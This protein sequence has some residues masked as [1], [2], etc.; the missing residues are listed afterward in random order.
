MRLNRLRIMLSI[1][2]LLLIVKSSK[3]QTGFS[4]N[5]SRDTLVPGCPTNL[6]ITLK[7]IIPDIHGQTSDYSLNPGSFNSA[8]FPVY[9]APNDPSGTPTNLTVDDT[10]SGIINLSFNFPFF[11]TVY[12]SLVASTN[13]Y[14]S[15]DATLAGGS[16]HWQ[17][18]GNLPNPLYDRALIMGPYHDLDPGVNTSPTMRIQ[19]QEFGAAPYRKWILSFYKVPLFSGACNNLIENT[20]Q[21]ILFESTGIIEVKIFD[22]QICSGWNGGKAMVGIQ[23]FTRTLGMTA[24]NRRMSDPPWGSIGMNETWR[25]VPNAGPSLLK[26]V[27][28][29]NMAGVLI[30]T[31]TT[32]PLLPGC[33]EASFPNI[34]APAGAAT[35]YE[36]R[37]I[38]EKIDDPAIEIVGRDTVV[39]NRAQ[40]LTGTAT[41]T[42]ANCGTNNGT[43]TVSGVTGG[44]PPY[45]YSLDGTNWQTSNVF[46]GLAPGSYTV[47]IRDVGS[48]CNITLPPV[49][50]A[51]VGN[52][53]A[54][55]TT[56]PT[57][58]F[59]S[60]TGSITITTAGGTGPYTFSLD[61]AA[62]V[63][64][65]L[66]FTFNNVAAGLHT[67]QVNDLGTGCTSGP[68]SVNVATGAGVSGTATATATACPGVNSGTIT[69]TALTGT[70]P[71]TWSL[72]GGPFL[73]GASPYTFTNVFG[74]THNVTIRDNF[75]CTV[76]IPNINVPFGPGVSGNAVTTATSCT[77]TNDGTITVTALT[78]TAP[79]TWSIDG[80]PF[81]PGASPYTFTNVSP[82]LHNITIV[83]NLN[84]S[85]LI[86]VTVA[87]GP[88]P[89]ATVNSTAT[90]CTGVN[91][92]TITVT[93]ASMPG[94]YTFSL[95]GGAPVAGT[96]PFTFNNVS[97]G[98]HNVVVTGAAGCATSQIPVTVTTGTGVTGSASTSSTSCPT[99]SNGSITVTATAGTAPF[100]WSLDGGAAVAGNSPYT[101]NNVAAGNHTVLIT[102]ALGCT[103]LIDPIVVAA[104]PALTANGVGMATTCSGASNGSIIVTALSGMAPYTFSLNGGPPQSGPSPFTFNNLAAGTYTVVVT[105]A[106]GCQTTPP[107]TVWSIR[108]LF[109]QRP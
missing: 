60:N 13:G 29:Y 30:A 59:G 54:T 91:N 56:T 85:V 43:I 103:L 24:P 65:T 82:G 94:P 77:G 93:S 8:C 96:L 79:F 23:D 28:L 109:C 12:N 104:G 49:T 99:A 38:Y 20:H 7:G 66:P 76:L 37:S 69:V 71:F 67:V 88:T 2:C 4:F 3:A 107:I 10:Y 68:I 40:E 39:I 101:F 55:H 100:T 70:A 58:C 44:T 102:D 33:L 11:G 75:N 6:C 48:V 57:A 27:E 21:I 81:L 9:V 61:G 52:I 19:Y 78:G 63:A 26:R 17:D 97:A 25:F 53:P 74:G 87:A 105:D 22:K 18:R 5:C 14:V 86:P 62:A 32:A 108:D 73:P 45:E 50:I 41:T 92:G 35:S 106:A 47:R 84:C 83:D 98:A 72:D 16:S 42:P 34:C 51:V 90:S 15:F 95:D 31:G 64:G 89:T 36:I 46:T 80:G 1:L